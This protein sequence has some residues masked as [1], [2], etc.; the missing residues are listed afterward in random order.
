MCTDDVEKTQWRASS[1]C[2]Y[3]TSV[4]VIALLEHAI[5]RP[6]CNG[7]LPMPDLLKSHCISRSF[8]GS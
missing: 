1:I 5:G 7:T 2:A 4:R 3:H 6:P 8:D